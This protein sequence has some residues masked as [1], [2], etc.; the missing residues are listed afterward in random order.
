[1]RELTQSP[2]GRK[3]RAADQPSCVFVLCSP[4]YSSILKRPLPAEPDLEELPASWLQGLDV[5]THLTA[6]ERDPST[7]R[8][9]KLAGQGL[10]E[11]EASGWIWAEDPRGWAQWYTRFYRGRRCADDERQVQRWL[12]LAGPTGRF[13]RALMKKIASEHGA[14]GA[15]ADNTAVEDDEVAAVLRQ[16]NWQWGFEINKAE[17]KRRLGSVK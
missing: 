6:K 13:S 15:V 12:N 8:F 3:R 7:N 10:K 9:R 14:G 5:S 17:W 16:V 1:M 2:I 4:A 11:W